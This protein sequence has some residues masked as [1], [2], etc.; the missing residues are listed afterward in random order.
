MVVFW[1]GLASGGRFR[2]YEAEKLTYDIFKLQ[3]SYLHVKWSEFHQEF[4]GHG[5]GHVICL[6]WPHRG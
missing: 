3:K 4:N 2:L 5:P 6:V 1:F